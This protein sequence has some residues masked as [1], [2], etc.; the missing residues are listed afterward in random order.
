MK[1]RLLI[2]ILLL[3]FCGG[4]SS[5]GGEAAQET[6]TT[7]AQETT[8]TTVANVP[9]VPTVDFDIQEI[10]NTKLVVELCD[11]AKDIDNTSEEC[12]KQYSDNLGIVFGYAERLEV[13]I[14]DLVNYFEEYPD[15]MTE[16][17]KN[18]FEFINNEWQ[19]VPPTYGTVM[20]KYSQ[21]FSGGSMPGLSLI[22]I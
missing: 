3:A 15:Q 19:S 11:D 8:T 16:E 22:H 14:N 2:L 21:R 5:E 13:Y 20:M 6:T 17:Y 9:P 7:A 18:L 1:I 12:L 10:Y 4:A